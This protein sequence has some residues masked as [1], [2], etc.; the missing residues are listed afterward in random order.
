MTK[1]TQYHMTLRGNPELVAVLKPY[2]ASNSGALVQA[3]ELRRALSVVFGDD[4]RLEIVA[5]RK[6][7]VTAHRL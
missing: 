6:A 7:A 2:V 5:V 4:V 1:H 3:R